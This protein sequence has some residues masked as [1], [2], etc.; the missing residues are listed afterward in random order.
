VSERDRRAAVLAA[1]AALTVTT[2]ALAYALVRP[3]SLATAVTLASM[4][5]L[6][7]AIHAIGRTHTGA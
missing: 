5:A 4:L 2:L 3:S 6:A 1:G 7:L